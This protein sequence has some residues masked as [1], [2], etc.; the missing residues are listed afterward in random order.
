MGSDLSMPN[1]YAVFAGLLIRG[2][3]G[4]IAVQIIPEISAFFL[5]HHYRAVLAWGP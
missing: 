4:K 1:V 3:F 5:A 2:G